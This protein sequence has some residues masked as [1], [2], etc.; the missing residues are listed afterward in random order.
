MLMI[1]KIGPIISGPMAEYTGW[2]SFWWLNTAML[3]ATFLMV[4]FGFPETKWHRVHPSELARTATELSSPRSKEVITANLNK[5]TDLEKSRTADV[6]PDLSYTAASSRDPYLGKGTPSRRQFDFFQPNPHP[7]KSI[8]LDL[9][10]PWKLFAFPI[11]EFASFVVSW[12]ASSFLTL[13][14]T[15]SEAFAAPPYKFSPKT[16]GFFNFAILIGAL[17]GLIT[18]GPLSDWVSMRLTRINR[19]IREP[20]MRLPSMI[21]YVIIM[22]LGNFVVAFGYQQH[23]DWKVSLKIRQSFNLLAAIV[24]WLFLWFCPLM[25]L[26]AELT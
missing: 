13:N 24:N 20:E 17:I 6:L 8:L 14:L 3:G 9:W 22:M 1:Y 25:C 10:I 26:A 19:G 5:S 2:R 16:I 12:S 18:A 21:P 7:L 15:Q 23:W 4:L 11:V